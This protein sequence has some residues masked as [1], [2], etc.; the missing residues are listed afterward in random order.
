[1]DTLLA[2]AKMELLRKLMRVNSRA[3]QCSM[4]LGDANTLCLAINNMQKAILIGCELGEAGEF[5]TP[6]DLSDFLKAE[7]DF[8]IT[9]A[10]SKEEALADQ[11]WIIANVGAIMGDR[12]RVNGV[13]GGADANDPA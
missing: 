6:T 12:W 3:V 1:M 4:A 8:A 13:P 5:A 10:Y 9:S 2:S 11:D 7:G